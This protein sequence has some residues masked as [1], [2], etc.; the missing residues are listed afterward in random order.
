MCEAVTCLAQEQPWEVGGW[1]AGWGAGRIGEL[2]LPQEAV[3]R[4]SS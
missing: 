4:L 2:R 1:R 3:E